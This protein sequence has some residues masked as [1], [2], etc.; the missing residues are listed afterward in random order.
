MFNNKTAA[1]SYF[2]EKLKILTSFLCWNK[3]SASWL[4][5][6]A[7][8]KGRMLS[9]SHNLLSSTQTS[10]KKYNQVSPGAVISVSCYSAVSRDFRVTAVTTVFHVWENWGF[11]EREMKAW[12]PWVFWP[13]DGSSS[14]DAGE[15]HTCTPPLPKAW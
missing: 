8:V 4:Q 11:L 3:H 5:L 13:V 14:L 2:Q 7:Y 1:A 9:C 10:T 6:Q 15:A 12:R